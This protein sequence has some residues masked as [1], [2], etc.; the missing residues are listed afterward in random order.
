VEGLGI[1]VR[2]GGQ[3]RSNIVGVP[4]RRLSGARLGMNDWRVSGR[5]ESCDWEPDGDEFMCDDRGVEKQKL[6]YDLNVWL[7][8]V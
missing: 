8:C 2:L 3:I 5:T 7:T 1:H 4:K 6:M